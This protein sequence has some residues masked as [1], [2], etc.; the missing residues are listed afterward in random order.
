MDEIEA[1]L[2][3]VELLLIERLALDPPGTLRAM[4]DQVR[5]AESFG[6]EKMIRAQAILILEDA[7]RRFD[8]FT[9]GFRIIPPARSE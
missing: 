1:R 4:I 6:D 7:L 2:A 8:E 3:A 5:A 9:V